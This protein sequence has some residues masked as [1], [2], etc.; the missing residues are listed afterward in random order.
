MRHALA[1]LQVY[2]D[3]RKVQKRLQRSLGNTNPVSGGCCSQLGGPANGASHGPPRLERT[4]VS[5][6]S[7]DP[8]NRGSAGPGVLQT[9]NALPLCTMYV[10]MYSAIPHLTA[11]YAWD[12]PHPFL[13]AFG[14][15]HFLIYP[16]VD[17]RPA[18]YFGAHTSLNH[19]N[20]R[21][22]LENPKKTAQELWLK[23]QTSGYI[24]RCSSVLI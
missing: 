11:R 18:K 12:K 4:S 17:M 10:Y 13:K 15:S 22:P 21:E 3:E 23:R 8:L 6:I 20:L 1:C 7:A 19:E 5:L 9:A 2:S 24:D 16:W 14:R